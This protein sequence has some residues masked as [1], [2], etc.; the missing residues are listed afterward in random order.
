MEMYCPVC[1]FQ[2]RLSKNER[3]AMFEVVKQQLRIDSKICCT[4]C[5]G[6]FLYKQNGALGIADKVTM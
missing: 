1:G 3:M 5:G 6:R 2:N 4:S